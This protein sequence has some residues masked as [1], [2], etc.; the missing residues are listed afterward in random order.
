MLSVGTG[1]YVR[2]GNDGNRRVLHPATVVSL[3]EDVYSAEIER[4][5]LAMEEG[6]TFLVYYE[7][8][9]KFVKQAAR[10]EFVDGDDEIFTIG[11]ATVGEPAS[12][13]S[14]MQFRVSTVMSDLSCSIGDE[15]E[16][17]VLDISAMG[18][19]A[20]GEKEYAIGAILDIEVCHERQ[21]YAGKVSVQ[22]TRSQDKGLI[23]YGLLCVDE[24]GSKS[25]L[26][27]GLRQLTMTFQRLQLRRLAG[28]T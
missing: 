26:T 27:D 6:H 11:F 16:C 15:A 12:A 17:K 23:R 28:T 2:V 25:N 18:I 8:K 21:R 14:R 20:V 19:S 13:E 1:F 24:K 3:S 5:R 7:I 4:E 22:G 10:I 9:G